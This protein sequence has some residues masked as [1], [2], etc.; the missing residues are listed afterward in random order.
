MIKI[1]PTGK[2]SYYDQGKQISGNHTMSCCFIQKWL[3][4]QLNMSINA[5]PGSIVDSEGKEFVK[6]INRISSKNIIKK[7]EFNEN[8]VG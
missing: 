4:F 1:M 2:N 7:Y 5:Y 3:N 8:L 6:L